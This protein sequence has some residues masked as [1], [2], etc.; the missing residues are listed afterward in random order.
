MT[1]VF[2]Y[3]WNGQGREIVGK[4]E[5][6]DLDFNF[7]NVL[8]LLIHE[9]VKWETSSP[10]WVSF[11]TIC[12]RE[13]MQVEDRVCKLNRRTQNSQDAEPPSAAPLGGGC[14]DAVR[15]SHTQK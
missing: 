10:F 8:G 12:E 5:N 3:Y 1:T 14:G 6:I 9:F 2:V 4:T 13:R 15:G 7:L 11:H